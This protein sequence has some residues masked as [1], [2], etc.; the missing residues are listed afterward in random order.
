MFLSAAIQQYVDHFS[1]NNIPNSVKE[2]LDC[3][4]VNEGSF[5]FCIAVTVRKFKAL[6]TEWVKNHINIKR[7]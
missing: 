4:L 1:R 7:K 2:L 6:V 5:P 3:E